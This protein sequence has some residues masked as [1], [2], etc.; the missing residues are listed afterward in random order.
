MKISGK[1]F[2]ILLFLSATPQNEFSGYELG[3]KLSIASGTLYPLLVKLGEGGL[4]E[5]RW[6]T[7]DPSELG[8]PRRR[9]YKIS[10]L[11]VNALAEKM[12]NL[13]GRFEPIAGIGGALA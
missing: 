13:G 10:G 6:E 11:G 9:Y 1:T 8:R 4:L 5:S 3:K 7:G 12:R 2:E